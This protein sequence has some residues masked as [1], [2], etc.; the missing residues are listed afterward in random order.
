MPKNDNY[1]KRDISSLAKIDN[2][3]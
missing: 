3:F 1:L 2:L